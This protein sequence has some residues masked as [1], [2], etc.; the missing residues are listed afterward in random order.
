MVKVW[1][2]EMSILQYLVSELNLN[3]NNSEIRKDLIRKMKDIHPD[4]NGGEFKNDEEKLLFNKLSEGVEEIDDLSNNQLSVIKTSDIVTL[5]NN[6]SITN[7]IVSLND[8][9]DKHIERFYSNYKSRYTFPKFSL[10]AVTSVLSIIWLFPSQLSEHPVLGDLINVNSSLFNSIWFASLL[11]TALFWIIINQKEQKQKALLSRFNTESYQNN[12]FNEFIWEIQQDN[13][14]YKGNNSFISKDLFVKFLFSNFSRHRPIYFL[15]SNEIDNEVA[16]SVADIVFSRAEEKGLIKKV[17][18]KS[19]ID[20]Y[21][22]E[23]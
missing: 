6:L 7:K 4:T 10:T 19:L 17:D 5:A 20:Q 21:E 11:F 9:L 8:N 15:G 1:G 18:T 3:G 2:R 22:I 12:L 14:H 23:P 13:V 16:Q